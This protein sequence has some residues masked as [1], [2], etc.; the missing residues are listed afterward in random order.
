[1]SRIPEET[2]REIITSNPIEDVVGQYVRLR[3]DGRNQKGLCPF[4]QEKTPS[5]KVH[6]EKQIFR[7]FGCG[8]SGNVIS[9]VM[10]LERLDFLSAVKV[11]AE[12]ANIVIDQSGD[13]VASTV[14]DQARRS[15]EMACSFY[16]GRL[17]GDALG[18][19]AAEYLTSRGFTRETL[20]QFRIGAAP[21][22]WDHLFQYLGREKISPEAMETAGLISRRKSGGGFYDYFRSR[23]VFPVINERGVVAGF[24]ARCLDDQGPKYLN[25]RET[26]F[27]HKGRMLYGIHLAA[28]YI[29]VHKEAVIVEG[30]TDVMMAVQAGIEGVVACLGTAFTRDNARA[31]KRFADRVVLVYDGDE[32]GIRAAERALGTLMGEGLD[33]RVSLLPASMDPCDFIRKE[34]ANAFKTVIAEAVEGIAFLV[35]RAKEKEGGDTSAKVRKAIERALAPLHDI[36]DPLMRTLVINKIAD[37]FGVDAS[38]VSRI[39]PRSIQERSARDGSRRLAAAQRV[40]LLGLEETMLAAAI[41][42]PEVRRLFQFPEHFESPQLE[43][44]NQVLVRCPDA[45]TETLAVD[46]QAHLTGT[47]AEGKLLEILGHIEERKMVMRK[48]EWETVAGQSVSEWYRKQLAAKREEMKHKMDEARMRGDMQRY[49][50]LLMRHQKLLREEKACGVAYKNQV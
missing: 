28:D 15:N 36:E 38:L 12:R 26:R 27:F 18:R 30:Y 3:P 35:A 50:Q 9:F 43:K 31:L 37:A 47:E 8:K 49:K 2:I 39:A 4:H 45:D 29:R 22:A 34:G 40:S 33:V 32:A 13:G 19:K 20:K 44:I 7:C 11:L 24:G 46:L 25:T 42:A 10:E 17:R 14:I 48:L 5:F 6:P 21:A 1:M 16:E 23:V 41:A